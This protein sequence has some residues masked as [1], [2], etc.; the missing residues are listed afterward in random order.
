M[1]KIQARRKQPVLRL[2]AL[3][4]R[5]LAESQSGASELRVFVPHT[6]AELT[7]AALA[8]VA[9]FTRSLRARVTVAAVQIVPFPLQLD[10]PHIPPAFLEHKLTEL[11]QEADAQ[12]DVQ[13]V[14]ARD[15]DAG[16][17]TVIAPGALVV[18]ATK[19]RWWPTAEKRLARALARSG[20][21]VA[22]LGV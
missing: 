22:L 16:L 1:P 17:E 19:K 12:V 18:V 7:R 10:Q 14:I 13:V 5:G 3:G 15:R 11:A 20:H 2:D 6:S 8:A 9:A 4:L 21:S